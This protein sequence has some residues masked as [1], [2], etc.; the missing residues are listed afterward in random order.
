MARHLIEPSSGG[1]LVT[2]SVTFAGLF[3]GVPP[4]MRDLTQRYL[5][6]EAGASSCTATHG[7]GGSRP[8]MQ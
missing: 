6:T 3:G 5:A 2:L 4:V 7:L 8:G 1:S